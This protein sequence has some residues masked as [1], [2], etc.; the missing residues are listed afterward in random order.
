MF[1]AVLFTIGK[2]WKRS[3]QDVEVPTDDKWIKKL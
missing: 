2:M 3:N 1:I